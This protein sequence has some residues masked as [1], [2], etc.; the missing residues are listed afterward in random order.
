MC[1]SQLCLMLGL[2]QQRP[3]ADHWRHPV[4]ADGAT[5]R[6]LPS[7]LRLRGL[8]DRAFRELRDEVLGQR[9]SFCLSIRAPCGSCAI[10]SF[11]FFLHCLFFFQ[12]V[13]GSFEVGWT[14]PSRHDGSLIPR[15]TA[16][17]AA[18]PSATSPYQYGG[19]R[20]EPGPYPAIMRE[21]SLFFLL[22]YHARIAL[23]AIS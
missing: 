18:D 8:A 10:F 17:L 23:I 21:L 12:W 13:E 20:V 16:W 5:A 15:K 11:D 9:S 7:P 19:V 3:L 1:Q 14:Q 22:Q 2:Q 6:H 4:V